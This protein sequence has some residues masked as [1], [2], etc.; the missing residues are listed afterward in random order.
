M[1]AVF[2]VTGAVVA[3]YVGAD[4]GL[5]Y[6][7]EFSTA[8]FRTAA[9]SPRSLLLAVIGMAFFGAVGLA[10]RLALPHRRHPVPTRMETPMSRRALAR[11]A[12]R[13]PRLRGRSPPAAAATTPE[14]PRA[15]AEQVDLILDWFPNADHAGIYGAIDEGYF[16]DEGL[17][18]TPDGAERPG[19]RPEAGRRRRARRSPSPTSPRCCSRGPRASRWWPS[20]PWSPTP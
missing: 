1:A 5:G 11:P 16:A 6:L 9:A 15:G 10:E 13:R 17:D 8:Q 7:S 12:R 19:G 18:V 2:A 14:A 20:A 3:E 4:R